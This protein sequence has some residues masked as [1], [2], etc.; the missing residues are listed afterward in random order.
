[1]NGYIRDILKHRD[2]FAGY[3]AVMQSLNVKVCKYGHLNFR[4]MPLDI[5]TNFKTNRCLSL[6][7]LSLA[8]CNYLNP[9]SSQ[10]LLTSKI[11]Y[12]SIVKYTGGQESAG[13]INTRIGLDGPGIEFWWR[14]HFPCSADCPGGLPSLLHNWQRVFSEGK[15]AGAWCC[16]LSFVILY[17]LAY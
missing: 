16:Y 15:E 14:Q 12:S 1:M 2:K 7:E 4:L 10:L 6:L 3:N 13:S 5:R 17:C 8:K 11:I 9:I